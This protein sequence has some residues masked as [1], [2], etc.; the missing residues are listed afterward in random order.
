MTDEEAERE[1]WHA[2]L[3][4]RGLPRIEVGEHFQDGFRA[5]LAHRDRMHQTDLDECERLATELR[6]QAERSA[7]LERVAEAARSLWGAVQFDANRSS[8]YPLSATTRDGAAKAMRDALDALD[9]SKADTAGLPFSI[10]LEQHVS[11]ICHETV[12]GKS[13]CP[14]HGTHPAERGGSDG[15]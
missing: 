15:E 5:G 11:C 14:V 6:R 9:R 3:A 7:A 10:G 13:S 1:A 2:R 12:V 4:K 8:A